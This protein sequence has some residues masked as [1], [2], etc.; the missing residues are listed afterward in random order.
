MQHVTKPLAFACALAACHTAFAQ[1]GVTIGGTVDLAVNHSKGSLTSRTQMT[2]GGNATSKLI[3]RGREDLGSGSY[4]NFW[5]E[6]GI[7]AQSGS[8][9]S[10]PNNNQVAVPNLGNAQGL[11]FNRRSFVGLGGAWGEIRMGREWSPSYETFTGKYDP[12]ALSIG[13]GMNY[14]V[15]IDRNA[16]R[17]NNALVYISPKL[18]DA[19]TINLQHFRGEGT[20]VA[21][22]DNN[23]T[24]SG[25]RV[26]YDK[27]PFSAGAVYINTKFAAGD[28]I[29]RDIAAAYNFG[30]VRL[31]FNADRNQ[32]GALKQQGWLVGMWVPFGATEL[33]ASYSTFKANTAGD[34]KASKIALGVVHNLSKRTAVYGTVARIANDNGAAYAFT[35]TTTA[36]NT[37]GRAGEIG[38]RHNF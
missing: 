2:S 27:G 3:F 32:Q 17:S 1:S 12:F 25:I 26:S 10:V 20:G 31:S 36:A 16:I 6:S 15:G 8:G 22:T 29:Y 13:L 18:L 30:P 24:G 37:S 7:S 38:I 11:T 4:A 5:L 33:K 34:P 14:A 23:G 19:V 35:G 9:M 28:A 21:A